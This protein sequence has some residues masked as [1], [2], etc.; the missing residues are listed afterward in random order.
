M[1]LQALEYASKI[2]KYDYLPI[3]QNQINVEPSPLLEKIK[4]SDLKS[5]MIYAGSELGINGGFGFGTELSTVPTPGGQRFEKF[6]ITPVAMYSNIE[7]TDMAIKLGS[8]NGAMANLLDVEIRSSYEAAKWNIAR[9]LFGNGTGKLGTFAS[10]LDGATEITLDSVKNVMIGLYIDV[11]NVNSTTIT[12]ATTNPVRI[13]NVDPA[14]KKIT[15]DTA[16]T[17]T[18]GGFI[19]V[20]GSYNNEITGLGAIFDAT[21]A[22]LY[23][24]TKATNTW[25][26]PQVVDAEGEVTDIVLYHA[27]KRSK[28]MTGS[29]IDMIMMADDAFI[30][31]QNYMR[32]SNIAIVENST[33]IGGAAG[34]RIVVGN[35]RVEVV[36][37]PHVPAGKAWCVDTTKLKFEATELGF[38]T[39]EGSNVFVRMEDYPR[40]RALLVQYGNIICSSPGGC[41]E[42]QNCVT[43]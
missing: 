25:I 12:K 11:Y 13:V 21:T 9:S 4:K 41:V 24:V 27:V 31:Y 30:A 20:Q 22:S 33:Y 35:K 2:L 29:N 16:V 26:K 43:T 19:T 28:D 18:H 38:A 1:A 8:G 39:E 14:T 42:I 3:W 6:E 7:I 34:Y 36:N 32:E 23:G 10:L 37:E 5:K 15:V 17:T 40:Y